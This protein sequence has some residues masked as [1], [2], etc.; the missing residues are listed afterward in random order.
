MYRAGLL[1]WDCNINC[2]G[3]NR[4]DNLP[5]AYDVKNIQVVIAICSVKSNVYVIFKQVYN[6]PTWPGDYIKMLFPM[7]IAIF[8]PC[9][10][11]SQFLPFIWTLYKTSQSVG[12]VA[13]SLPLI[14]R[15]CTENE[16]S[17]QQNSYPDM[18]KQIREWRNRGIPLL[19]SIE[20]F[21]RQ[22]PNQH[23]IIAP[24]NI[25]DF[26]PVCMQKSRPGIPSPRAPL[27]CDSR[28]FGRTGRGMPA[29]KNRIYPKGDYLEIIRIFHKRRFIWNWL[30]GRG[31][32]V[33][34]VSQ[35]RN[36]PLL[37]LFWLE[38]PSGADQS[39]ARVNRP[40]FPRLLLLSSAQA[41]S[42]R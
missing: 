20:I 38:N 8:P 23:L 14:P 19:Q 18:Y 36:N 9:R 5:G 32:A 25:R 21:P 1:Y 40:R 34:S 16:R 29:M 13:H 7:F 39:P 28:C 35:Y 33:S 24:N 10:R 22:R 31:S 26:C 41:R 27:I 17:V 2:Y 37:F 42:R 3:N 12:S 6:N 15:N 30:G 11:L 4:S